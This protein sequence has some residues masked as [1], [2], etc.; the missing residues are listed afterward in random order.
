MF[1]GQF[2]HK[3]NSRDDAEKPF[4]ISFS[5]L[6]T[7]LMI[8]FLVIMCVAL[9]SVTRKISD[10]ER[11]TL[12]RDGEITKL[13]NLLADNIK[14]CGG[15]TIRQ[16][17][18]VID[19]GPQANFDFNSHKLSP[20]QEKYLRACVPHI[21][22]VASSALG[23]KWI[24]RIVVEGYTD[25]VGSYLVNL[26]LSLQRSQRVLCT[27]LGK[28]LPDEI[29]FTPE[30]R[31]Q[32]QTLFLVGGYSFNSAKQNADESRRVEMRLE[33]W[34]LADKPD[35]T[36]GDVS[37]VEAEAN[38]PLDPPPVRAPNAAPRVNLPPSSPPSSP[39]APAPQPPKTFLQRLFTH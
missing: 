34:G 2:G 23:A 11:K 38:C 24:K 22:N 32:I 4:W 33:F 28:S 19:F 18:Y 5:D 13:L 26:N 39:L 36:S 8:L 35:V 20:T 7:A 3:R 10:T 30:Q 17:R 6:M 37:G 15:A 27:L 21:L 14:E 31:K 9:L 12:E 25:Q 16:D 29:E 1:D